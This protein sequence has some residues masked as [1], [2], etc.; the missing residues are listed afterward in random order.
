MTLN[1]LLQVMWDDYKV[2][3]IVEE[4]CEYAMCAGKMSRL[5]NQHIL[6]REIDHID[7]PY[8][9]CIQVYLK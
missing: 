3:V 2:K 8:S 7:A 1:E 9:G 4:N 6:A 5:I